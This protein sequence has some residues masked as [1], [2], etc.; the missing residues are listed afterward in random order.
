M[1]P[2][3]Q[4]ALAQYN[5]VVGDIAGN[6][7]QLHKAWT[8]A[9]ERGAD[10]VIASEMCVSG[11]QI[12]DMALRPSFLE[13]IQR[14]I[15]ELAVKCADGPALLVGAPLQISG[16][17]FNAAVLLDGG[18]IAAVT[19]K[20]ELPNYGSFDEQRTF[21][22][23]NLA[24][25]LAF[26][27]FKLG[28]MVCEDMWLPET[29]AALHQQ[30]ADILIVLNG[31]P[32]DTTKQAKRLQLVQERVAATGLA[33]IYVNQVGGQDELVFDGASFALQGDGRLI[34]QLP[35]WQEHL[36]SISWH[37]AQRELGG[38]HA[39]ILS[40]ETA[41]IYSAVVLGLK[42][43]VRKNSFT[44]VLLGLSGGIDSAL[45]AAMAVDALGAGQVHCVMMPSPYTSAESLRD[46]VALAKNLGVR[47]D[48]IPI[49]PAMD[50]FASSLA[51]MFQGKAA[52]ITEENI[53]SRCRGLILMALSNK[54]G[55]MVLAT[56]NKSEMAVGYATLYGDMCGGY[57][58]LKDVY[59]TKVYELAQWRNNH[60]P[61]GALGGGGAII[62]QNILTR[63]PTAELKPNQTDQDSL[64]PYDVLDAILEGLV[65]QDLGVRELA[66]RGFD[67]ATIR[68]V[69]Q[70]LKRAEY[71]RRQAP[72]GPKV[73]PRHLS[74]DRR[75]PITN[76]FE[77]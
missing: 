18:K 58:P 42:D 40:N 47:L 41:A 72:P 9:K 67:A 6:C 16:A 14:A 32:Y 53:Q 49:Q 30:G 24:K 26:R 69:W 13:A 48:T 36:G 7:A 55:G 71:K 11:Y 66:Q 4:L 22:S 50:V 74:K 28:V 43:Y 59:K 10:L 76:R 8:E 17:I 1:T 52:D 25:P 12:E 60:V 64:P 73:T 45:V 75:Y 65:E 68:R 39:T 56:G 31:S 63:A 27:G 21:A 35:A 33:L 23:G 46:A 20:H 70:M 3:L 19:A 34:A 77:D 29:A 44:K 57:A 62:P 5:F 38:E 15:A 54:L 51:P 61:E 2:Q 37:P